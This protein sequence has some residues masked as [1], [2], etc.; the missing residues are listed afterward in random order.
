MWYLTKNERGFTLVEVLAS[1]V[2]LSIVLM[3][4]MAVFANTNR[5]AVSNSEK[6][7]VINLADAYL[8]RVKANPS[9]FI[10]P[11]PPTK[12]NESKG[13]ALNSFEMNNKKYKVTIKVTQTADEYNKFTLLNIVV[14][15][16]SES[17]KH[18]SSVEG[19][20]PYE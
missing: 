4:F 1:L 12:V 8:E 11:F 15:V 14:T 20:I 7:V 10:S 2:I 19:Y 5:L 18:K 3:S 9:E 6:L 13:K 16:N 17:S